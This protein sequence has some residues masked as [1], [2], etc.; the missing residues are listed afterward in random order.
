MERCQYLCDGVVTC[1]GSS[2]LLAESKKQ[3]AWQRLCQIPSIGPIRSAELLPTPLPDQAAAVD[4]LRTGHRDAQQRR[5]PGGGRTTPTGKEA[6]GG[7]R[8]ERELQSRSEEFVQGSRGGGFDEARPVRKILRGVS[9]Q[10]Y[11]PRNG[12]ADLSQEDCHDCFD[13]VEERSVLRRQS[14]ET[15]NNLSVSDRVRSILGIFSGG[16]LWVLETPWF[17]SESQLVS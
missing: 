14:S 13:C 2:S 12:A 9:R 3:K 15:T 7:S 16:G 8:A 4:L 17:E 5:S 1:L 10:G 11:T 6:G